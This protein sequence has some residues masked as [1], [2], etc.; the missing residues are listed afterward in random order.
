[1]TVPARPPEQL[2]LDEPLLT[3]EEAARLLRATPYWVTERARRGEIPCVRVE[4]KVAFLRSD[5]L[6]F[7]LARPRRARSRRAGPGPQRRGR[8][9]VGAGTPGRGGGR[10][11]RARHGRVGRPT[12]RR[13]RKPDVYRCVYR[14]RGRASTGWAQA[15]LSTSRT[16]AAP[17]RRRAR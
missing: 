2:S 12:P 3:P 9:R 15:P 4:R 8:P 7:G 14:L 1:M 6:E 10:L 11:P 5:K 16:P 13:S 17:N